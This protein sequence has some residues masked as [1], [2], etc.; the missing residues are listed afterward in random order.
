MEG[1]RRRHLVAALIA[2]AAAFGAAIAFVGAGGHASYGPMSYLPVAGKAQISKESIGAVTGGGQLT[3]HG[4][5]VMRTN[6]VYAI[7]WIPSGYTVS[8]AYQS[9]IDGYFT[10]VAADNGKTSNVYATD[11]QYSDGTGPIAYD[12][13]FAGS[14]VDTNAF[15]AS[16][17]PASGYSVCLSNGQLAAE[18]SRVATAQGWARGTSSLYFVFT[19]KNV[20]G[21]WDSAG[22]TCFATSYCAYHSWYSDSNGLI[23]FASQPY[24]ALTSGCGAGWLNSPNHDDADLTLNVASHEHNEAITDPLLNAWYDSVGAENGDKCAWSFATQLGGSTGAQYNQRIGSGVYELQQEWSNA[25]SGCALT[26]AAVPA[27]PTNTVAP[28]VSGTAQVGRVLTVSPGSWSPVASSYQYTWQRC[29]SGVCSGI[30][31]AWAASYTAQSADLGK[32]LRVLVWAVNAAGHGAAYTA[33]T[34]AVVGASTVPVNTVL[35]T[36][37]GTAKVGRV[38]TVSPGSWSPVAG[39]YQYTWQRCA[40]GV[41]SGISGAWAASYTAQSADL[42]KALRVL[43]WAVNAAGHGAAT[44]SQTAAVIP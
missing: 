10:N 16:G 24:A 43:V 41:C 19:P 4:G 2:A 40:S 29:A 1:I 12:S 20:T 35:P 6:R 27:V 3:Y 26:G 34:A 22:T 23:V 36:V 39:S 32:A 8:T 33:Q 7:Y 13:T 42:G 17:C 25:A 28:S 37:S 5:S 44:T 30:S 18:I 31:G 11:T 21:C 14:T 38:L 15:P 9:T